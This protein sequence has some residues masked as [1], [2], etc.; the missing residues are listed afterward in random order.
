MINPGKWNLQRPPASA[1]MVQEFFWHVLA[2]VKW[3][4]MPIHVLPIFLDFVVQ[5][6]QDIK[7]SLKCNNYSNKIIL[8]LVARIYGHETYP[9]VWLIQLSSFTRVRRGSGFNQTAFPWNWFL[10]NYPPT[11][12]ESQWCALIPQTYW[13]DVDVSL[14]H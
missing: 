7:C 14:H 10:L 8:L 4:E 3:F 2:W 5:L 9:S 12:K 6:I 1:F 13:F 11:L